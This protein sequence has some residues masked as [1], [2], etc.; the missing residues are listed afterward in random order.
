MK[1]SQRPPPTSRR[2]L[3]GL[4]ALALLAPLA[5]GPASAQ[6]VMSWEPPFTATQPRLVEQAPTPPASK[7]WVLC[8]VIP[9]IKD[10]YWLGIN[11]GMVDEA[12]RLRVELRFYE[13]GG[14]PQLELQRAQ[15]QACAA[16]RSV[17]ALI[18]GAI[19]RGVM[20]PQL[21]RMSAHLP[22]IGMVNAID[23]AGIA[24]KVGVDWSEMGQAA[25]AFLAAQA[26]G[27]GAPVPIAWFPGPRS[28]SAGVDQAFRQAIAGS[29]LVI[30]ATA[31]GDTGKT[32][33]RNLLQQVL[34]E[35]PGLRY[36]AGNALM[37]EA[38]IS[39]LRERGLQDRIG[40][41]STYFTPAV[42][43]G[44]LRG[45]ILAAPTDAP[46]LQGRLTVGMAVDLLEQRPTRRHIAPA[47]RLIDRSNI[48]QVDMSLS[49]PPPEL[50]P[51]I[52]YRPGTAD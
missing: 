5:H 19:A 26:Q 1:S 20:T 17:D 30:R 10:A 18:V 51:Q 45:R 21:R 48:E 14:Y 43:R 47:V 24:G 23:D 50:I 13:A 3:A 29:R 8:I 35:Q 49:L 32:E 4:L 36:V 6:T 7:P 9:H 41:V 52:R 38:A 27:D 34:D 40:V 44:I 39:V 16:D 2:R 12:R 46:V 15:I 33:Q 42:Q 37:A 28:V 22:V 31:W 11:H 25:G